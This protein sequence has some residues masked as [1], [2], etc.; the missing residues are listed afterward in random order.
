MLILLLAQV[1]GVGIWVRGLALV[2]GLH[3]PFWDAIDGVDMVLAVVHVQLLVVL[4]WLSRKYAIYYEHLILLLG[5]LWQVGVV[6][7]VFP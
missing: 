4:Y 2:L 5:L 7:Q 6:R 1:Q 3:H